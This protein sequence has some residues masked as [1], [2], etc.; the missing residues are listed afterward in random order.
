MIDELIKLGNIV[1]GGFNVLGEL[2]PVVKKMIVVR[3]RHVFI[4]KFVLHSRPSLYK[5][6]MSGY[7]HRFH[8]GP[9]L[10]SLASQF[11]CSKLDFFN[12]RKRVL[13][14]I[15]VHVSKPFQ[16]KLRI[17]MTVESENIQLDALQV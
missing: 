16:K 11:H 3:Y 13:C 12:F 15:F 2:L 4:H 1:L 10:A 6:L 14:E 17:Q 5:I 9:V 7:S 8:I